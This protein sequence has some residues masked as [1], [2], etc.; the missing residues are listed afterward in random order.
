MTLKDRL[1][2]KANND[3]VK[4]LVVGKTNEDLNYIDT[5]NVTNMNDLFR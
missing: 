3:N 1:T 4:E 2:I 5:T